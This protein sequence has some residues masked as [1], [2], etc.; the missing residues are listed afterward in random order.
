MSN[1][2]GDRGDEVVVEPWRRL[3]QRD[4]RGVLVGELDVLDELLQLT[5]TAEQVRTV[6]QQ[7]HGELE[8]VRGQRLSV[9]PLRLRI[10]LDRQL[11][12]GVVVLVL[13][14]QPGLQLTS[15]EA[16]VEHRLAADLEVGPGRRTVRDHP[17]EAVEHGVLDLADDHRLVP[18]GRNVRLAD[19]D[20][21]GGGG[22]V[23]GGL[24]GVRAAASG[25][26]GQEA[27]QSGRTS[28]DRSPTAQLMADD[29]GDVFELW[30]RHI[31]HGD[32]FPSIPS[33]RGTL[34]TR[35][36]LARRPD[37]TEATSH[38]LASRR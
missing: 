31:V 28:P 7:Q 12:V 23:V 9:V 17:V 29:V 32:G 22:F 36:V 1:P 11:G 21:F 20:R 33:P 5:T 6:L 8:V 37:V 16:Q 10:E 2:C 26:G 24:V 14:G 18:W 38:S 35:R 15:G 34:L 19:L 3:G 27:G 4:H 25:A 30:A 13:R